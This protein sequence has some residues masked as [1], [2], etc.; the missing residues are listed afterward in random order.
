MVGLTQERGTDNGEK[1]KRYG[2]GGSDGACGVDALDLDAA[3]AAL[4]FG[5]VAVTRHRFGRRVTCLFWNAL[6]AERGVGVVT[7]PIG[8]LHCSR[9]TV[10]NQR[11]VKPLARFEDTERRLLLLLLESSTH[12]TCIFVGGVLRAVEACD[13]GA[14]HAWLCSQQPP[15]QAVRGTHHHPPPRRGA[16]KRVGIS[17]S[18]HPSLRRCV[19]R[20]RN[21][22]SGRVGRAGN[23]P[24]QPKRA[25]ER[26][27]RC[28]RGTSRRCVHTAR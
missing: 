16:K 10:T 2:G 15:Q 1:L 11:Q 4:A 28:V 5:F 3:R 26:T 14:V 17:Y 13:A 23:Y 27:Q 12:D 19:P 7:Q 24:T 9:P 8:G 25:D 20:H 21:R 18:F 6:R 22:C